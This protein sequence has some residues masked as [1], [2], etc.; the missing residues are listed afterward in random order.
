MNYVIGQQIHPVRTM[1]WECLGRKSG[2][3]MTDAGVERLS[4]WRA[5]RRGAITRVEAVSTGHQTRVEIIDDQGSSL[6]EH[7]CDFWSALT[8]DP[9]LHRIG[10]G[11][12]RIS[13]QGV[14]QHRLLSSL[15]VVRPGLP[16]LDEDAWREVIGSEVDDFGGYEGRDYIAGVSGT[17]MRLIPRLITVDGIRCSIALSS[18]RSALFMRNLDATELPLSRPLIACSFESDSS[19]GA[20]FDGLVQVGLQGNRL[21]VVQEMHDAGNGIFLSWAPRDLT[22]ALAD[23]LI[24]REM[25]QAAVRAIVGYPG[26]KSNQLE[27]VRRWV[28][29]ADVN[30]QDATI[31]SQALL[32]ALA[33]RRPAVREMVHALRHPRSPRGRVVYGWIRAISDPSSGVTWW[34]VDEALDGRPD[35][36]PKLD[37][38]DD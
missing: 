8:A 9:R 13:T 27:A 18:G 24:D 34:D 10:T 21:L 29:S 7:Q 5:S 14:D 19:G 28:P 38:E 31:D 12:T 1:W 11:A 32:R 4:I 16:D 23:I 6:T 30:L 15:Q 20:S 3:S 26:L 17:G 36:A 2:G 35:L 25:E 22:K 33:R 37:P